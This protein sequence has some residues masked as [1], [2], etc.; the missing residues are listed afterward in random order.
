M[1][2]DLSKARLPSLLRLQGVWAPDVLQHLSHE[3]FFSGHGRQIVD[4]NDSHQP[5]LTVEDDQATDRLLLHQVGRL[6]QGLVLEAVEHLRGH[7]LANARLLRRASLRRCSNGDVAIGDDADQTIVFAHRNEPYAAVSHLDGNCFETCLG[8]DQLDFARH[9]VA[10]SHRLP[11]SYEQ[12]TLC[13]STRSSD[14]RGPEAAMDAP[15]RAEDAQDARL[16]AQKLSLRTLTTGT[17]RANRGALSI[18]VAEIDRLALGPF[19]GRRSHER[20][21]KSAMPKRSLPGAGAWIL[22]ADRGSSQE[23]GIGWGPLQDRTAACGNR[24]SG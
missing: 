19:D 5:L 21:R 3:R 7:H 15:Q 17:R 22:T 8:V 20:N 6:G 18:R 10:D 1:F 23:G 12:Q 2:S 16:L 11:P 14:R 4:G 24:L 13:P 9:Y